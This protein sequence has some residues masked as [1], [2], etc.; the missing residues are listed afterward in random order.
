MPMRTRNTSAVNINTPPSRKRG[1]AKSAASVFSLAAL[2]LLALLAGCGGGGGDGNPPTIYNGAIVTNPSP[3]NY[4]GGSAAISVNVSDSSGVEPTSVKID[5]LDQTSTSL[6]GGPQVMTPA[7]GANG[8]VPGSVG[9]Y[10][11]PVNL[12][13]NLFGTAAKIYTVSVSAKDLKG[14]P[15]QTPTVIGAITVPNPPPPP[16]GP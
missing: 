1:T 4:N 5:V 15:T 3:L 10:S 8:T 2:A 6:I 16:S 12:P 7:V 13:N 11:F 14:N 9:L